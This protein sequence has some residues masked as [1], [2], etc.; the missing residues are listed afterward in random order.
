MT[1]NK[2][3]PYAGVPPYPS[4]VPG[5]APPYPGGAVPGYPGVVNPGYGMPPADYAGFGGAQGQGVGMMG[6]PP[7]MG[8]HMPPGGVININ[9]G[10]DDQPK[11]SNE[12][13]SSYGD[14]NGFDFSEKTIRRAF[15]RK[16]YGI[17]SVQLL[18]TASIIALFSLHDGVKAFVQRSTALALCSYIAA[19]ILLLVIGCCEGVRRKSPHNVILLGLFTLTYGFVIGVISSLYEPQAVV[20]AAIITTVITVG[21]TVFAFQTKIDFT[22]LGGILFCCVLVMFIFGI[23]MMFLPHIPIAKKIYACLGALLFS[24]YLIYDTQLMIGGNHKYSISPE[25]YVF[26]A[27]NIY[28]DIIMIFLYILRLFGRE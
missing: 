27:L 9:A 10:A 8:F 4:Q 20:L 14:I 18:L 2:Q 26:A 5:Q 17:L 6:P 11:Y 7:P 3:F 23:I 19:I 16:V 25:E 15:I 24:V 22:V 12:S 28:M 1:D 21:L 13:G